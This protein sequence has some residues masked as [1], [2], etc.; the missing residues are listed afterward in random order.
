MKALWEKLRPYFWESGIAAQF[1]PVEDVLAN[2][3][4]PSYFELTHQALPANREGILERLADDRLIGRDVGGRWNITN[5][6]AILFAQR[7]DFFDHRIARKA[8]RFVAYDGK[9]RAD[10]VTHRQDWQRGYANGFARFVEYIDGLLPHNE[11]IDKAFRTATPLYPQIAIRELVANAL[12]H[13]DMTITGT[14]P[15]IELFKDR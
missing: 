9:S 13:Q 1:L 2:L 7:L 12:I 4:Y 6:G 15:L 8:V 11:H 14:G 5:V 3:D 10:T